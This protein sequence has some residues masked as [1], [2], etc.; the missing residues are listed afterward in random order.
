MLLRYG[1]S[2]PVGETTMTTWNEQKNVIL[3]FFP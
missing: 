3:R 1:L 2:C